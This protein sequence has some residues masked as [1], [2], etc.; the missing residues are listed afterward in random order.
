MQPKKKIKTE[1]VFK[2]S[3]F[4]LNNAYKKMKKTLYNIFRASKIAY[5][6]M[7]K[8]GVYVVFLLMF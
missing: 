1:L 7:P 6:Y 8:K 5:W 4:F 3:F 2:I